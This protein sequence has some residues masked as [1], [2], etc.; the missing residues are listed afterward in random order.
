[1][2]PKTY[3]QKNDGGRERDAF[4]VDQTWGEE[5]RK[6]MVKIEKRAKRKLPLPLGIIETN[7]SWIPTDMAR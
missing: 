1:M 3:Q 5:K 2:K 7:L 6:L 4:V